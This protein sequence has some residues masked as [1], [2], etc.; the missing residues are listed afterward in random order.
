MTLMKIL[1]NHQYPNC[2]L[3]W[4]HPVSIRVKCK[5]MHMEIKNIAP[6]LKTGTI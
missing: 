4:A 1:K 2:F 5:I 6:T 3:D